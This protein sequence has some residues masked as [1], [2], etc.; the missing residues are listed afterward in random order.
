M[1]SV[2]IVAL[3]VIAC[4]KC[5]VIFANCE[6]CRNDGHRFNYLVGQDC[7]LLVSVGNVVALVTVFPHAVIADL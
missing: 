2:F 4:M 1:I 3:A 5:I 6:N 7:Y